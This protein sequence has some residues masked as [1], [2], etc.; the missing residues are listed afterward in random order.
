MG[1]YSDTLILIQFRMYN[2][3]LWDSYK[4]SRIH[5]QWYIS[6]LAVS[7]THVFL[8]ESYKDLTGWLLCLGPK[9][10]EQAHYLRVSNS[11]AEGVRNFDRTGRQR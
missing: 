10:S 4:E 7:N 11:L 6:G 8:W 1:H 9:A 5:F 3:F 2:K